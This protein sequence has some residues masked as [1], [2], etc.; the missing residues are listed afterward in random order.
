MSL[1]LDT[2]RQVILPKR[3]KAGVLAWRDTEVDLQLMFGLIAM[4]EAHDGLVFSLNLG[5]EV[6]RRLTPG[7][8]DARNVVR[9][10]IAD[11]LKAKL[12]YNVPFI[13]V[14]E[15][16]EQG[17]LHVHGTLGLH[18]EEVASAIAALRVAGGKWAGAGG[19]YQ[20]DVREMYDAVGWWHYVMKHLRRLPTEERA[21]WVGWSQPAKR[22][23][24]TW[25]RSVR[26]W[27]SENRN[28]LDTRH[29]MHFCMGGDTSLADELRF[30]AVSDL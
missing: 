28:D 7:T 10:R 3:R 27:W 13:M 12:G 20:V 21:R 24:K 26:S 29:S 22:M 16:E 11:G 18:R 8:S 6:T 4:A 17:R 1:G 5:E 15:V 19:K 9:K 14:L 23:A 30:G 2:D 25:H